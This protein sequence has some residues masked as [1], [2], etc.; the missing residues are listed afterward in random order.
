MNNKNLNSSHSVC[1]AL[2]NFSPKQEEQNL[3]QI[4]EK[5]ANT[6]CLDCKNNDKPGKGLV[7]CCCI[8]DIRINQW[9]RHFDSFSGKTGTSKR[10]VL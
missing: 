2:S 3:N 6:T 9:Q 4:H 10:A 7:S 1:P 5:N 8:I